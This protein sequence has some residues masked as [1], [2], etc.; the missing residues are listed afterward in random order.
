MFEIKMK[1][2]YILHR[3]RLLLCRRLFSLFV[4]AAG[5][6]ICLLTGT[7]FFF[8]R[9]AV[10][11]ESIRLSP[12][13]INIC[14]FVAAVLFFYFHFSERL[15]FNAQIFH[16]AD[17]SFSLPENYCSPFV[18]GKYMALSVTVFLLKSLWAIFFYLPSVFVFFVIV[19]TLEVGGQMPEM[20]LYAMLSAFVALLLSGSVFFTVVSG[21]YFISTLLFLRNP[22]QR[23]REIIKTS[24]EFTC[25]RLITVLYYRLSILTK[26]KIYGK[27]MSVFLMSDIFYER[28]YYRTIGIDKSRLNQSIPRAF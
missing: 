20:M 21:R 17:K 8:V 2:R 15:F 4:S 19:R 12:V 18:V 16:F 1:T 26:G 24:A 3:R 11:T 25:D 5:C 23:I 6:V 9:E 13:V 10:I 7:A 14:A 27:C 28:K 22:R